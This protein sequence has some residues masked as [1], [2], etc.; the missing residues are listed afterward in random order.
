MLTLIRTVLLAPAFVVVATI[1]MGTP[2][3]ADA[4]LKA[5]ATA[6][7][8]A[9]SM[10]TFLRPGESPGPDF[11]E[12]QASATDLTEFPLDVTA[13]SIR[14]CDFAGVQTRAQVDVKTGLYPSSSGLV[15]VMEIDIQSHTMI[16]PYARYFDR[17]TIV[18]SATVEFTRTTAGPWSIGFQGGSNMAPHGNYEDG[19]Y[20]NG[21]DTKVR[22][23]TEKWVPWNRS[24]LAGMWV[25]QDV[26][27]SDGLSS[28]LPAAIVS[29]DWPTG[30]YRYTIE[31][32][33]TDIAHEGDAIQQI[34]DGVHIRAY[35]D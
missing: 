24:G 23:V 7:V 32:E 12:D 15:R 29:M 14:G 21:E 30:R 1:L 25:E 35:F 28:S 5:S 17:G 27:E 2:L 9:Y 33:R 13:S 22:I 34:W 31:L 8:E 11:D 3:H 18:V 19:E 20:R 4:I 16:F 10:N 6:H 26:I